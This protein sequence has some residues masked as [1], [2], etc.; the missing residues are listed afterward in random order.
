VRIV[1]PLA[2]VLLVGI[3]ARI[4]P[5]FVG[6][7]TPD[8]RFSGPPESI[9]AASETPRLAEPGT[10]VPAQ[11]SS[12][13]TSKVPE[14][15]AAVRKAPELPWR[16]LS[17]VLAGELTLTSVQ[18]GSVEQILRERQEEIRSCHD[19]IRKTR[20]LDMRHYEWQVGRMKESW[21]RKIDG[22]LD[23]SQHERF[24]ALVEQG[25]FNDG[26]GF[27]EDPGMTVLD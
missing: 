19:Q 10:A 24:V 14:P 18:Q 8:R 21:Y 1:I 13:P 4:H 26:L 15:A 25:F 2:A 11:A 16:K 5:V 23:A 20:L 22:L 6:P 9:A 3:V 12:A 7:V 27:T 17:Q